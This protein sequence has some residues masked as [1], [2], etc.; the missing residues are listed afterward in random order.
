MFLRLVYL[1][2]EER[3]LA[4]WISQSGLTNKLA[5]ELVAI[6]IRRKKVGIYKAVY[7][8]FPG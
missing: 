2:L 1:L 6:A 5:I 7:L 8:G 4:T 3:S